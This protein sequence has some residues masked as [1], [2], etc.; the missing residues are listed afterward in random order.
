[1]KITH[2]SGFQL[3]FVINAGHSDLTLT[4][5]GEVVG[6][7]CDEWQFWRSKKGDRLNGLFYE[8]I[9]SGFNIL[10]QL[11]LFT[12][13]LRFVVGH[14]LVEDVVASFIRKLECHSR[15]LQ[16]IYKC[17][18]QVTAWPILNSSNLYILWGLWLTCLNISTSQFASCAEMDS[19]EFT[20]FGT[21]EFLT[22]LHMGNV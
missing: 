19:D 6:V 15:L 13:Q 12:N 2:I 3:N 11:S 21:M 22:S 18:W 1:M 8:K 7:G 10:Q 16:Q 4:T 14:H 5:H 17:C 20:L 9:V